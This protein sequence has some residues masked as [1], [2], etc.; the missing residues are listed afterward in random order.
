MF[1]WL[2]FFL[3]SV[4]SL[5]D[6]AVTED[7]RM[8]ADMMLAD[9]PSIS[10]QQQNQQVTMIGANGQP[11]VVNS[12]PSQ[13]QGGPVYLPVGVGAGLQLVQQP[14]QQLSIQGG[15]LANKIPLRV[16][17]FQ[18]FEGIPNNKNNINYSNNYSNNNSGHAS[19]NSNGVIGNQLRYKQA[20]QL[21]S[22]AGQN[23]GLNNTTSYYN[24]QARVSN[25]LPG[26][27]G[28]LGHHPGWNHYGHQPLAQGGGQ[29]Q[30]Q[31]QNNNTTSGGAGRLFQPEMGGGVSVV[32]APGNGS[33]H[34]PYQ[35]GYGQ[36]SNSN[37]QTGG[38]SAYSHAAFPMP[39]SQAMASRFFS[40]EK[41]AQFRRK[42]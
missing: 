8:R 19:N 16:H 14:L 24:Q 18:G 9:H 41:T 32:Y 17:H 10:P 12:V 39:K 34:S 22:A 20:N 21:L 35:G 15:L 38:N 1:V 26:G 3:F 37:Q 5:N 6:C 7:E 11:I 13:S 31:Q 4:E 30:Q 2:L 29:L 28:G 25:S 23:A 27:G 33:N 40:Q 42:K 36:H